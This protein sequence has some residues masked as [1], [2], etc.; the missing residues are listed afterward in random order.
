M[1]PNVSPV[2][3]ETEVVPAVTVEAE[4]VARLGAHLKKTGRT[5][6][7]SIAVRLPLRLRDKSGKA[8]Q[9][10]LLACSDLEMALYT[11]SSP[12]VAS[13]F[14]HTR[15]ARYLC[16]SFVLSRRQSSRPSQ[17]GLPPSRARS[18][19]QS[20]SVGWA[21]VDVG[22]LSRSECRAETDRAPLICHGFT[23]V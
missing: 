2:V 19:Q 21:I 3:I 6:L 4:A 18:R 23:L 9:K 13:R 10:E 22:A 1:E 15:R 12:S 16:G 7:S 14:P 8:L 11:G 5:I 20:N 17:L